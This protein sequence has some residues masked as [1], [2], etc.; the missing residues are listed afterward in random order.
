MGG[1]VVDGETGEIYEVSARG[2]KTR[3]PFSDEFIQ[4]YVWLRAMLPAHP[5]IFASTM[6]DN[7]HWY[8]LRDSWTKD[9]FSRAVEIIRRYGTRVR[10]DFAYYTQL[11]VDGFFYWTM[12]WPVSETILINRKPF[13]EPEIVPAVKQGRLL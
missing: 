6:A 10:Y 4:D 1:T 13:P 7:P 9:E 5:W 12:G 11:P 8:T 3:I 2:K